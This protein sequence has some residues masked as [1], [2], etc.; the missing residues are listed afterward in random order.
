MVT[1]VRRRKKER[2]REK[3]ARMKVSERKLNATPHW[4]HV[5]CDEM[6]NSIIVGVR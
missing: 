3:E 4:F 5:N 2:E 1:S 6:K